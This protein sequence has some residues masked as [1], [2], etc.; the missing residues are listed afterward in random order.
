MNEIIGRQIGELR[1]SLERKQLSAT[2][3][4]IA[5]QEQ[6]ARHESEIGAFLCR[7][8]ELAHQQA[9]RIDERIAAG[10]ELPPLAG[11]PIV[12]KDNLC[13]PGFPTTCAS[14]ILKNFV[15]PYYST[16]V[17]RL[18][19]AGAVCLGKTN[20]DEFA[21]GSSTENSSVMQTRNPWNRNYVPGGSSGGSAAAVCAGFAVAGLGSDTGGSIRQ[22]ASFC[23]VVGMKPTYGVVSRFGLVAFASSLDQ[24]GPLARSVEDAGRVLKVIA[25]HDPNDSTSVSGDALLASGLDNRFIE[26]LNQDPQQL[27]RGKR[28]GLIK[29]LIGPGIDP[30][31]QEEI[32]SAAKLLSQLGADVDEVSIPNAR[33]CLAVYYLIATAEASS[34]L[35]RYDGVRYGH[36]TQADDLLS[37]YR[38]TRRDGFGA[39][40][41]LRIMLGTYALSSGYY[42]AYYKKAQQ[43]RRLLK[44]DFDRIFER[45]DALI[46][47]TSPSVAFQ[48]GE[49]SNDPLS[50]YM[51]D[52]ATIPAN[53]AGLPAVSVPCGSGRNGLPV[54]LQIIGQSLSDANVL[55][56]AA[57]FEKSNK[58]KLKYAPLLEREVSAR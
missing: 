15:P 42:D 21:M 36:R 8:D 22:P 23:G 45:C 18:L 54:G 46:C 49:K 2:E 40:V 26:T 30:D 47:P 14:K 7:T 56:I 5:H 4:L 3:I 27:L 34:N 16:A 11:V 41:K 51:S 32:L 53:L 10:E 44:Q 48:I 43:V 13:L 38:A 17:S 28:L 12:L 6:I 39:E 9:R 24:I 58:S 57:A 37:M 25:G 35:A 1:A 50:M 29:E 33:H 19:D 55:R 31:V 52:I 20:M